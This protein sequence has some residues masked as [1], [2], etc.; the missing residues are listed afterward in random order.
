M[1]SAGARLRILVTARVRVLPAERPHLVLAFCSAN[2]WEED[3][4]NRGFD[5]WRFGVAVKRWSRSTQ[6]LYIEPG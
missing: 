3:A 2:L 1:Q 6:L 5:D 4:E